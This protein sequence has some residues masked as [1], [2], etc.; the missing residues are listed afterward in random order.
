[1]KR[2]D[3]L[4]ASAGLGLAGMGLAA[5]RPRSGAG[6][7]LLLLH[8]NDTQP[9]IDPFPDG[10]HKRQGGI[11][12]RATLVREQRALGLP[13]LL[14]DAGDVFQGTPYFNV[15]KGKLDYRLMSQMGYDCVTL[16]NHDFDNGVEGLLDAMSEAA[17]PFVNCNYDFSGAPALA[18]RVSPYWIKR[19]PGLC[20]GVTGVGP[21][22]GGLV[23]PRNHAGIR[24]L[25]PLA[26]LKPVLHRL[27]EE[28]GCHAVIV[29]S[30]LGIEAERALAPQI[31]EAD[32]IVGGHSHTF[33]KAPE[34]YGRVLL[35]QVGFAGVQLGRIELVFNERMEKVAQRAQNLPVVA[36][37]ALFE[38]GRHASKEG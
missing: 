22:F 33:M 19:F 1:M 7:R 30:H 12:R 18:A 9:R 11:A 35:N 37:Q 13:T 24:D 3:F 5:P 28:E 25:D 8:T 21:A 34:T 4:S 10:P 14:V 29:L 20:V 36:G 32:V 38:A 27:R 26:S 6:T 2:R 17:F 31:Q 15:W 16:G 23:N